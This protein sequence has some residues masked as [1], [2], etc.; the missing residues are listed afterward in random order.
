MSIL[1]VIAAAALEP[2]LSAPAADVV[3][4]NGNSAARIC[5]DWLEY[6]K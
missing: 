1:L 2:C 4:S 5:L 6:A 3:L